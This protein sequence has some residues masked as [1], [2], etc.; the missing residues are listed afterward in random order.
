MLIHTYTCSCRIHT[1]AINKDAVTNDAGSGKDAGRKAQEDFFNNILP[2]TLLHGSERVVQELHVRRS[3]RPNINC[4][5]L[6]P[7]L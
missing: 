5:F 3:W 7:L 1:D 4:N 2:L 6:T